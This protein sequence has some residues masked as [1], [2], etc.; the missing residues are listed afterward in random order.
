MT[1][2]W[3]VLIAL[4]R[5]DHI[6]EAVT[7]IKGLA[8]E[9]PIS[10]TTWT[11]TLDFFIDA[12]DEQDVAR[13]EMDL[14][15][16]Q[17]QIAELQCPM[18]WG[19]VPPGEFSPPDQRAIGAGVLLDVAITEWQAHARIPSPIWKAS[20]APPP[21]F[22]PATTPAPDNY[23]LHVVSVD[24]VID[25]IWGDVIDK[26]TRQYWLDLAHKN[27]IAGFV[28][29]PPCRT[30]PRARGKKDC[31]PGTSRLISPTSDPH[32]MPLVR[33]AKPITA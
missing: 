19:L 12:L 17:K 1:Y 13:F 15:A 25:P 16:A 6:E 18:S 21:L 27:F 26:K 29:G 14:E 33:T 5:C 11:R 3:P 23:V 28:A 7:H 31:A 9:R 10:W 30:W 8:E 4:N 22:G 2:T 24:I 32:G 20:R